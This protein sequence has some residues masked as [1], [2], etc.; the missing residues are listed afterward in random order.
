MLP[1]RYD[2]SVLHIGAGRYRPYERGHVSYEIW[3]ELASGFRDYHVIGRS[4]GK[5]ARWSDGNLHINLLPSAT[6]REAEFLLRQF[7]AVSIGERIEPDVIVCQSPVLGGL[8]AS[9]IA[10]RTGARVLMEFHGMEYFVEAHFASRL[11]L[12]QKLTRLILAR[13]DRIRLVAPSMSSALLEH[14][15][16]RAAGIA[17]VVPPRVD[18]S[19]FSERREVRSDG[20]PLRIVMVGAVNSNKGQVRLIRALEN[21]PFQIDLHIVGTGPD[22]ASVARLADR[23]ITEGRNLRVTTHGALPH[24]KVADVLNNCDVFV[25]YSAMEAAGRAMMEAMATGL[26]A[27]TTNAGSCVDFI[28]DGR[29]G[30]VLGADPDREIVPILERFTNRP[31]LVKRMGRAARARAKRDY[32]SVKLFKAYRRLIAETAGR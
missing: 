3:R 12:L 8:A 23:M 13:A 2:L 4:S 6:E 7:S 5:P 22:L 28:E 19:T 24:A 32:D 26:P 15:G 9:L 27:I 17:N 21:V 1:P 18:T 14:Y 31:G 29:E 25:F 30:F 20:A 16:R 11:W 10:R